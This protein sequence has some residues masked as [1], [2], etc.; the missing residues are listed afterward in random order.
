MKYFI[1]TL[2]DKGSKGEREDLSGKVIKE[3]MTSINSKLVGYE[4][5]PDEE[6]LITKK[7]KELIKKEGIDLILTTGGTG[8]TPRD[9]TPEA[10]LKVIE[11]RIYG[12]EIAMIVEA[13]KHTPH[14]MLSRAIVGI[15]NETL[16]INLPGSPKAVKENLNVLLPAIPHAIDKI[17]NLGGDCAR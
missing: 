11:K 17:K 13:L 15:A 2:S 9:V 6:E 4:I 10:T 16:I 3:I 7:L 5:L 12:M 1:L 14:G 8:L